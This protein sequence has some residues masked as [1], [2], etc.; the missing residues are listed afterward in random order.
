MLAAARFPLSVVAIE[1]PAPLSF[2]GVPGEQFL[3]LSSLIAR[4][5]LAPWTL[6]PVRRVLIASWQSADLPGVVRFPR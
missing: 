2:N 6:V 1:H 5:I 3:K 4:L